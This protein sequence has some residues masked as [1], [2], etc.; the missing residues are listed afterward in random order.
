MAERP[1][2]GC[3]NSICYLGVTEGYTSNICFRFADVT[4][5]SGVNMAHISH[6]CYAQIREY[7]V[8]HVAA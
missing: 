2:P 4:R 5:A 7:D 8:R 3:S 6:K 1:V